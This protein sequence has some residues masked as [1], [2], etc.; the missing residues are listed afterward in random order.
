VRKN[1]NSWN[2]FHGRAIMTRLNNNVINMKTTYTFLHLLFLVLVMFPFQN[3]SA[4]EKAPEKL[5]HQ[6]QNPTPSAAYK[7][8]EI[9]LEASSRDVD[10]NRARPTVLSR[11]M[12][13]VLTAMYDAWAAYD[14]KAVGTRLGAS[15]RRPEAERTQE[16]KE[17]AIAFAAYR[18]LLAVYPEDKDWIRDRM[19]SEGFDP[20]N[21]TTDQTTPVG[22]GNAAAAAVIAYRMNDGANQLGDEKGSNGKPYSDYTG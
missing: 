5:I 7:W 14:D 1:R 18:G 9:L 6:A 10:K 4:A 3:A 21:A 17:Q 22:I 20:D 2:F 13:I 19:K 12:S 15:L 11:T 8:L 16:N